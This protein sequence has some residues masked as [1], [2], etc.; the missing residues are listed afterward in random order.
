MKDVL[1]SIAV[2]NGWVFDY[3][4]SDYHNIFDKKEQKNTIHL[5]VDP[6]Q[7]GKLRGDNGSLERLVYSGSMMLLYSSNLSEGNYE[8]RYEK[9]IKP[10]IDT[11]I[12]V[13]EDALLCEHQATIESWNELEVIN[14]FDYNFDGVIVTFKI[15]FEADD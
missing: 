6:L 8:E 15:S 9:Y 10:I 2:D 12:K 3:A 1:K 5:F 4:R 13:V 11:Q 7:T 14:I